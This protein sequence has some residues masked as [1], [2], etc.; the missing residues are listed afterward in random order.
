MDRK[1]VGEDMKIKTCPFCNSI[2]MIHPIA[3]RVIQCTNDS[4]PCA[5]ETSGILFK[6]QAD[7]IKAWN[8]RYPNDS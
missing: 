7:A 2:A 3:T 1:K 6:T 8:T 5:P 4:C